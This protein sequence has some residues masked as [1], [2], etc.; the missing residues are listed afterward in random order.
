MQ[1]TVGYTVPNTNCSIYSTT[2]ISKAQ[3][4]AWKRNRRTGT[5]AARCYFRYMTRKLHPQDLNNINFWQ[6]PRQ[7]HQLTCQHRQEKL[8][9]TTLQEELQELN[10]CWE[11]LIKMFLNFINSDST[12]DEE[13]Q[14]YQVRSVFT[15]ILIRCIFDKRRLKDKKALRWEM[16][17]CV[18]TKIASE[19]KWM[20]I[21]VGD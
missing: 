18:K 17:L 21:M 9:R 20:R 3:V 16:A 5:S 13:K 11:S 2:P 7:W 15:V 14:N 12:Y 19:W 4:T 1:R 8:T 10:G 6:S